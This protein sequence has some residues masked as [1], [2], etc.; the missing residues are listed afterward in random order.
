[1]RTC[2]QLLCGL[3]SIYCFRYM[4]SARTL[5]KQQYHETQLCYFPIRSTHSWSPLYD[6]GALSFPPFRLSL[7]FNPPLFRIKLTKTPVVRLVTFIHN[8]HS[9]SGILVEEIA[10]D[11]KANFYTVRRLV[12]TERTPFRNMCQIRLIPKLKPSLD[13]LERRAS[14]LADCTKSS[15]QQ[16]DTAT[17]LPV[18]SEHL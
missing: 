14:T 13:E 11:L 8:H 12:R 10:D 3:I 18:C 2:I 4:D 15:L 16:K 5:N 9:I 17:Q 6:V 1:M 7:A